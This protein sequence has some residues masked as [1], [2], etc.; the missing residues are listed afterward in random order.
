METTQHSNVEY[1]KEIAFLSSGTTGIPKVISHDVASLKF[2]IATASGILKQ[3]QSIRLG[4]KLSDA[5]KIK[6][7]VFLPLYHIFGFMVIVI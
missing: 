3:S 4:N 7:L 5:D 1:A 6:I 2:Q